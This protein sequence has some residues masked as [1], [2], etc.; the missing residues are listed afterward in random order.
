VTS[1]TNPF[2]QRKRNVVDLTMASSSQSPE[3]QQIQEINL[4]QS[5][6]MKGIQWDSTQNKITEYNPISTPQQLFSHS[7]L[8]HPQQPPNPFQSAILQKII[9]TSQLINNP[10]QTT[11]L[12]NNHMPQQANNPFSKIK[13]IQTKHPAISRRKIQMRKK[14]LQSK[15]LKQR[16]SKYQTQRKQK[17]TNIQTILD[18]R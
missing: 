2:T 1:P 10:F 14:R 16:E 7:T 9:H 18:S 5:K 3:Q 17:S 8:L 4:Q 6:R 13:N 11:M 15:I 12:Q